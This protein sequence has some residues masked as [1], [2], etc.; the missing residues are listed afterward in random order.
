MILFTFTCSQNDLEGK[1]FQ[2]SILFQRPPTK[3]FLNANMPIEM[4]VNDTNG[5]FE[6]TRRNF[7]IA[8]CPI[9]YGFKRVFLHFLSYS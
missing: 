4:I 8:E 1:S 9:N 2:W 6:Q 7:R 5:Y 3:S